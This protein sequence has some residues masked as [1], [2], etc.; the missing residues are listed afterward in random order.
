M[1]ILKNKTQDEINEIARK[2]LELINKL[3]EV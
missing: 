2:N 1:N 3:S